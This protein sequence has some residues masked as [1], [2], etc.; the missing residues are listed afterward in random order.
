MCLLGK[1]GYQQLGRLC[2]A[3]SE[4]LKHALVGAGF[5]VAFP[6]PTFNEFVVRRAGGGKAAPLL[7]ALSA[8]KIFGGIDLARWYPAL[9]DCFLVAVTERHTRAD[10]DRFVDALRAIG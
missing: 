1:Q 4:Y 5:Q 8:Q 2:L 10:L 9:D 3:R 7:A 6:G